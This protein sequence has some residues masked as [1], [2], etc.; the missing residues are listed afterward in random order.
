[1]AK[2]RSK[3]D[4]RKVAAQRI[5]VLFDQAGKVAKSDPDLADEYVAM[6]R[7]MSM[8]NKV[9][10]PRALKRRFCKSCGVFAVQGKTCRVRVQQGRVIY[11]CLRCGSMARF[12]LG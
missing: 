7:R 3:G 5:V 6:A 9:P 2:V 8:R 12:V 10:I 4:I 11:S 1:M